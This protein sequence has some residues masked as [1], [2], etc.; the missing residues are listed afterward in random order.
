MG[1]ISL[2]KCLIINSVCGIRSTG[3][4]CTDI[5]ETLAKHGDEVMIAYGRENVPQKYE[6]YA[7]RIGTD[8][9]VSLHGIRARVLDGTGFGSK[10]MTHRFI[11]WIINYNP[12]VIHLHNL[13]GYYINLEVLF[14][15][16]KICGKKII[17][18][19]H[20]CWSFTGHCPYFDYVNCNKWI[21]GCRKC[22]QKSEYPKSYMDFSKK[23]WLRKKNAFDNVPNMSLVTP[24]Q[25]LSELVKKSFLGNYPIQIIHNGVDTNIFRPV[26]SSIREDFQ[27]NGKKIVLGVAA[28]WNYR[29]GLD[30]M[31]DISNKLG[32]E[33]AVVVIGVSEKQK[34]TLPKNVIGISR[35]SSTQELGKWYTAAEVYVNPTLE[36][37]YP[38]TN[39]EAIA[40]GTPVI[41]FN[42]G[43]SPESA[44]MFG[45][46]V[47]KGDVDSV[48]ELIKY[49]CFERHILDVSIE[50][51]VS[52]YVEL[53]HYAGE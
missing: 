12:D 43:G 22:P 17:W 37:N 25:W 53:Y 26:S 38:T 49:G 28:T 39:L 8:L 2:L 30:Y 5:A 18:T 20:D 1:G 10:Q 42:A 23:N 11:E 19:L 47:E 50:Y 15:Y 33:Y 52:K 32:N 44:R 31:V 34:R 27:I 9:D 3:R 16:L 21:S 29:K 4:I 14:E 7:M 48:C 51:M 35:T 46:V 24:S 40:C 6:K 45:A 13:H 36:D 41:T